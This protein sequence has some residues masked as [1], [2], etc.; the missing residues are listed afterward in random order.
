MKQF[1]CT[2]IPG[3]FLKRCKH[4]LA[5]DC[6]SYEDMRLATGYL[7]AHDVSH[8]VIE[9]TPGKY[10]VI[11]HK[12]GKFREL[13]NFMSTIPGVDREYVRL[14]NNRKMF[15][16]R[17][18]PRQGYIPV[19]VGIWMS[20]DAARRGRLSFQSASYIAYHHWLVDFQEYWLSA[21][22]V[23][24]SDNVLRMMQGAASISRSFSRLGR[25][26]IGEL[27][28]IHV[29]GRVTWRVKNPV[30]EDVPNEQVESDT[31]EEPKPEPEP[32]PEITIEHCLDLMEI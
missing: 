8:A 23:S 29:N 13:H 24:V 30:D 32:D 11:V 15:N 26:E 18:Y 21:L 3:G 7:F 17:A 20:G 2:K 1:V 5:L 31:V 27:E 9:S 22:I 12:V 10:W 6:D 14:A 28:T 25:Q 16:L 19:L 4:V